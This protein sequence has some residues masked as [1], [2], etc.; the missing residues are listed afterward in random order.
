MRPRSFAQYLHH[1]ERRHRLPSEFADRVDALP[2][3]A[4]AYTLYDRWGE[5]LY[6]G[7]S[8]DLRATVSAHLTRSEDN[9]LLRGQV[10]GFKVYPTDGVRAAERKEG[11]MFDEYLERWGRY[12]PANRQRPPG[13]RISDD[14]IVRVRMGLRRRGGLNVPDPPTHPSRRN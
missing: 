10:R 2:D 7:M 14:E 3:C 13:S 12:P 4:G 9:P 8:R 5:L 11:A 6:V 1:R